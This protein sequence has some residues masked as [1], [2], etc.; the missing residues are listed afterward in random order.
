MKIAVIGYPCSGKTSLSKQLAALYPDHKVIHTD[1]YKG[2]D[3]A[4]GLSALMD[5]MEPYQHFICEGVQAFRVLRKGAELRRLFFDVVIECK[6]SEGTQMSR[7]NAERDAS[8]W[9]YIPAFN[10]SLDTIF[11]EY[12]GMVRAMG[13][14]PVYLEYPT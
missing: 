7:Y 12:R 8:K 6:T 5:D 14:E 2:T 1:D 9:Q 13:K 3:Y 10:K 4:E 11:S